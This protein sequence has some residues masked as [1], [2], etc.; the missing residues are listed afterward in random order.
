[1]YKFLISFSMLAVLFFSQFCYSGELSMLTTMYQRG[2]NPTPSMLEADNGPFTA[3]SYSPSSTPGYG[4]A[5]IWYPAGVSGPFAAIAVCPGYLE[6]ENAISWLGPRLASNGFVVITIS[7]NNGTDNSEARKTQLLLALNT[8]IV[9]SNGSSPISG[10]VDTARVG[11]AGH[12]LGGAGAL[13]ASINNNWI[14]AVVSIT[15]RNSLI[16]GSLNQPYED[17]NADS[18]II[19]CEEDQ[20]APVLTHAEEYYNQV[21]PKKAFL[22]IAGE[23]HF[24]GNSNRGYETVLGKYIISWMKI[25]L[26][27][28]NRYKPFLCDPNLTGDPEFSR[29]ITTCP[30]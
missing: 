9:E 29:Y 27:L 20:I 5:T 14:D 8:I 3:N 23:G 16:N 13:M 6:S 28:D 10:L 15:P 18:L 26:D 12:S 21:P 7:T 11:L 25:F 2:P 17:V 22:E 19:A 24:C 4:N 30:F 1:M